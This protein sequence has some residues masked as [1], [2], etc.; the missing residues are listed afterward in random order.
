MTAAAGLAVAV[1][2]VAAP[3]VAEDLF[4]S[5]RG[6]PMISHWWWDAV[7]DVRL[8]PAATGIWTTL[9]WH[10]FVPRRSWPEACGV[11]ALSALT[12]ASVPRLARWVSSGGHVP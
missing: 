9:S 12:L 3:V 7:E 2:I 5:R 1:S 6:W 10:L 4:L 8:R 11:G